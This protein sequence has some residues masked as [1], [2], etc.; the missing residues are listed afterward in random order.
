VLASPKLDLNGV[1]MGF[2]PLSNIQWADLTLHYT[3]PNGVGPFRSLAVEALVD[4][5]WSADGRWL[6]RGLNASLH[7]EAQ[8]PGYEVI[9]LDVG[10]DWIQF[11][12]REITGTG[13]AFERVPELFAVLWGQTDASKPFSLY[14]DLVGFDWLGL[15][16][17]PNRPGFGG[18]LTL[19]W[20]PLDALE[21]RI[22]AGMGYHP[23]GARYLDGSSPQSW[24]FGSQ[25]ATNFTVTLRQQV[26][27]TPR[28]S[29]QV[30]AQLFSGAA[31][32][33]QYWR[34]RPLAPDQRSLSADQLLPYVPAGSYD[35][36]TSTLNLNAVLRWEYRL[37]STIYVVYSRSQHERAGGP[38]STSLFPS[39]LFSGPATDTF[40][41]KFTYWWTA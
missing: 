35:E 38:A 31:Y 24:V 4:L 14:L 41:I 40:L 1:G 33:E 37:G 32:Y 30:Y 28:L 8:L 39:Q 9:G 15:G 10:L 13:V 18:D 34:A 19:R 23:V 5:N 21:T 17:Q 3:R 20:Q 11:D 26:V 6:P 2:Q 22:D 12:T 29:F 36:H 27:I 7:A 16:P 25:I